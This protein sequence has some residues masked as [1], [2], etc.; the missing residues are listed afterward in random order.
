MADVTLTKDGQTKVVDNTT[1]L[2]KNLTER[3]W[4]AQAPANSG[5]AEQGNGMEAVLKAISANKREIAISP[6]TDLKAVRN[7]LEGMGKMASGASVPANAALGACISAVCVKPTRLVKSANGETYYYREDYQ[8]TDGEGSDFKAFCLNRD[9]YVNVGEAADVE[10][11]TANTRTGLA[12][13]Y[14]GQN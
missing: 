3:G 8:V 10:V 1:T 4:K 14:V 5:N 12:L 11:V 2:F 6:D 7:A 9:V 13:Q